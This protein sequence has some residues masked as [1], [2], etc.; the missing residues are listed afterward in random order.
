MEMLLQQ[1][2]RRPQQAANTGDELGQ[3]GPHELQVR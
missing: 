1:Q 2:Q 3:I